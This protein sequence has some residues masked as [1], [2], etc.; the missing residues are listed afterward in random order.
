MPKVIQ[1]VNRL[2]LGG[3]VSNALYMAKYM[4]PEYE[5]LVLA[6]MLEEEEGS[7]EFLAKEMGIRYQILPSMHRKINLW[8]DLK[9]YRELKKV[10][11]DFQ[12]DILHTHGAKAGAIGRLAASHCNVKGIFHTFH[13]HVFHS[14]FHPL[15]TQLFLRIEQYL[16]EKSSCILSVS[17]Q[18]KQELAEEYKICKADKIQ[19]IELG[20]DLKIFQ[21]NLSQKRQQFRNKYQINPDEIAIGIVGRIVPIKNHALFLKGL[22]QVLQKTNKK[23]RAFIIGDGELRNEIESSARNLD[24]PFNTEKE[25][26]FNQPLTFTSWI[27]KID[28]A[29][30]GLDIICLTSLNEG[31]PV[32]LIEAQ[33]ARKPIITTDVGGV[34][35]TVLEGQTALVSRSNDPD[36][37]AENLLKLINDEQLRQSF[38]QKGLAFVKDKYA[39]NRLIKD[40]KILYNNFVSK[41]SNA[42]VF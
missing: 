25:T 29:Y 2:S 41:N 37:L 21:E 20:Y 1:I 35:D 18:I 6:G 24:I 36:K 40:M 28:V 32:S 31:T 14:Y 34:R 8:Q 9:A 27:Q 19:V 39:Y 5:T 16:A 12:P 4:A 10:I 30:A 23:I 26:Q 7:Y 15:K 22:K 38:G 17:H 33:A 3:L 13:G 42:T 11:R